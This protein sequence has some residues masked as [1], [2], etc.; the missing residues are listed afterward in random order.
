MLRHGVLSYYLFNYFLRL[1]LGRSIADT[2]G[3]F[4]RS[5]SNILRLDLFTT[6]SLKNSA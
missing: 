1:E 2:R 5:Y 3:V 4:R 6:E